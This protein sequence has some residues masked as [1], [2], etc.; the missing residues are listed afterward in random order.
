MMQ[1]INYYYYFLLFCRY[2]Y[3]L[4]ELLG[5]LHRLKVRSESFDLWA[6]KVKEALE[7][8]EGNKIG[9]ESTTIIIYSEVWFK[10]NFV[11]ISVKSLI[12]VLKDLEVLKNE[13]AEKK[14]PDNELLRRLSAVLKDI[15]RCQRTSTELLGSSATRYDGPSSM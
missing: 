6:N 13:A 8:E 1:I 11:F 5:M 15:E 14:F 9:G 3:T 12:A 10:V 4:D 2:R 7:Q